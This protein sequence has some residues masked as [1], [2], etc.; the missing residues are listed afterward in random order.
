LSGL[1][2]KNYTVNETNKWKKKYKIII[3]FSQQDYAFIAQL[4][5]CMAHGDTEEEALENI[6]VVIDL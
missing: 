1:F 6:R 5:D 4:P 2:Y 3:W